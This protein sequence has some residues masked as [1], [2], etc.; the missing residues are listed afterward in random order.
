VTGFSK[1][2]VDLFAYGALI[3]VV[4]HVAISL[5]NGVPRRNLCHQVCLSG[6]GLIAHGRAPHLRSRESSG[7]AAFPDVV[8]AG[9]GVVH[10]C[11]TTRF[12]PY[13]QIGKR[14]STHSEERRPPMNGTYHR[15]EPTLQPPHNLLHGHLHSPALIDASKFP[16]HF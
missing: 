10:Q 4:E 13:V 8:N 11:L 12:E 14:A 6:M 7:P 2:D 16:L 5:T 9:T 15:T 3:V 1:F